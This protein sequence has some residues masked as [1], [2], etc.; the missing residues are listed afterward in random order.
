MERLKVSNNLAAEFFA[1][2]KSARIRDWISLCFL[3]GCVGN[4]R[5]H[6]TFFQ[7]DTL[8]GLYYLG[9]LC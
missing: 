2:F 7:V 4:K 6:S 3:G 8:V 5:A 1:I 9:P